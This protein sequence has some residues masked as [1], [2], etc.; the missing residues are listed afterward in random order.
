MKVLVA[1]SYDPITF[2]HLDI[3][4]R[5]C[6]LFD[7]VLVLVQE[8]LNKKTLFSSEERYELVKHEVAHLSNCEVKVGH[9]LTVD[10]AK[11]EKVDA[12]IRGVRSVQDYEYEMNLALVNQKISHIETILLFTQP[13]YAIVSS[14]TVKEI[15]RYQGKLDGFVS[16]YIEE[17]LKEKL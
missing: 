6:R 10:V 1:G 4:E 7:E 8:N 3:I 13:E 2:G 14:S 9:G 16:S 15:A 17:K 12:L 5:C 11:K